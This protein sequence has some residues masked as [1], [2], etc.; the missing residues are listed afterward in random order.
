MHPEEHAAW[1]GF[2]K[3]VSTSLEAGIDTAKMGEVDLLVQAK[4]LWE[5]LAR[6][7]EKQRVESSEAHNTADASMA[8]GVPAPNGNGV[9]D[10][11]AANGPASG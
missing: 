7:Q 1:E 8:E 6:A 5:A 9:V 3:F 2:S 11:A 10:G 4:A